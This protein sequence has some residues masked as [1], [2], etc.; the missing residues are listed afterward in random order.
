MTH[1]DGAAEPGPGLARNAGFAAGRYLVGAVVA[2]AV[3]GYM[4]DVLGPARFGVWAIAGA[5]LPLDPD[6]DGLRGHGGQSYF[7][8]RGLTHLHST[9]S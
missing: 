2:L 9:G 4:L 8:G 5:L 6:G 3:T 7:L 1:P